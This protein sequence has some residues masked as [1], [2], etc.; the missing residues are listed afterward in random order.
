MLMRP[1][2]AKL[3]VVPNPSLHH[4]TSHR[5]LVASAVATLSAGGCGGFPSPL[6]VVVA[7]YLV[8]T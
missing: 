4:A 6:A 7:G 3:L 2:E 1:G 8:V 5:D